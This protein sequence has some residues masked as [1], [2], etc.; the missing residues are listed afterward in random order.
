MLSSDFVL[1]ASQKQRK[2]LVREH[3]TTVVLSE[4]RDSRYSLRLSI[5]HD[6]YH[7]NS[8]VGVR[9]MGLLDDDHW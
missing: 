9:N 8:L 1:D 4:L 7:H 5:K 3:R 6:R 2:L